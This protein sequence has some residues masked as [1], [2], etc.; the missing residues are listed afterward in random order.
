[1]R[2]PAGGGKPLPY[3]PGDSMSAEQRQQL[4]DMIDGLIGDD[5]LRVDLAELAMNLEMLS[6]SGSTRTKFRLSGDEPLS[7]AEAMHLTP[8][9]CASWSARKRRKRCARFSP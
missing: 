8:R 1:M 6:P 2:P 9:K 3:G 7:L 5:R 4:R